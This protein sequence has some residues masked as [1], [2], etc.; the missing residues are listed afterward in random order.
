MIKSSLE[1]HG[2]KE[3]LKEIKELEGP[4]RVN[5]LQNIPE[6]RYYGWKAHQ[7]GEVLSVTPEMANLLCNVFHF[8]ELISEG[9]I[10]VSINQSQQSSEIQSSDS[11]LFEVDY[12]CTH[13]SDSY[14]EF[15][16]A[17]RNTLY[18]SEER[19]GLLKDIT[20]EYLSWL[21]DTVWLILSNK[22]D[23]DKRI[24]VRAAKRGNDIYRARISKKFDRVE[25]RL[26]KYIRFE[27]RLEKGQE[28]TY[29]NALFVTLTID[30]QGMS[31]A[32]AWEAAP[33]EYNRWIT[34]LRNRYGPIEVIRAWE[35]HKKGFPH[36]HALLVF[37]DKMWCIKYHRKSRS[38]RLNSYEQKELIF[39]KTWKRGFADVQGAVNAKDSIK[40]MLKYITG[41]KRKNRSGS[42]KK[43][44]LDTLTLSLL[45]ILDMQSYAVS[46]E[47]ISEGLESTN[48]HNSNLFKFLG[49]VRIK[50]YGFDL[51][52]YILD[53]MILKGL[54]EKIACLLYLEDPG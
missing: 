8:G 28:C 23:P 7:K 46:T 11:D 1:N 36:I 9:E 51:D 43:I 45:W 6:D 27:K 30:P 25:Q 52:S 37:K 14:L 16:S 15:R 12:S 5:L 4:C 19:P 34:V 39:T 20:T 18:D 38:W 24:A 10:T 40:Y 22:S 35:S 44:E 21:S 48:M 32:E 29:T 2:L 3:E 47:F 41:V 33:K 31:I 42:S 13:Q 49:A 50:F 17:L 54:W 53:I 26:K